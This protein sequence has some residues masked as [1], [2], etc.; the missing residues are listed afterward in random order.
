MSRF[1]QQDSGVLQG[2][3]SWLGVPRLMA[4]QLTEPLLI[5]FLAGLAFTG[6][7]L[8]DRKYLEPFL[9]WTL[10]FLIPVA[11]MAISGGTLYDNFRQLFFVLPPLFILAGLALDGLF[12]RFN[13]NWLNG[14]VITLLALPGIYA[15]LQL[16]PYEYI[17]YNSLVGGVKGAFRHYELDYW[18]TSYKEAA[19]YLNE[20]ALPDSSIGV[21]GTDLIF[22][23][24]AR[25]DLR[26]SFFNGLDSGEGFNYVVISSRANNDLAICP[27]AKVIKAIERDEAVLTSVKQ[28]A[29]P[30]DC[31]LPP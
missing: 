16:H 23:P 3:P 11:W 24:Y 26:V 6:L 7:H 18:A 27:N 2:S 13:R 25:P 29:S 8:K 1:V 12:T 10:W 15:C 19:E 14:L 30:E 4:I 22:K 21:V 31:V 20:V 28:I 17:Y 5:L 9:L